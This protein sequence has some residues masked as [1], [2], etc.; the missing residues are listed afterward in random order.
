MQACWCIFDLGYFKLKAFA[1]LAT[2]GAYFLSRLNH[3]T[4]LLTTAAGRWHP[5]DLAHWLTTVEGQLL[6]RSIFLGEKERVASRLIA[7]RVPEAIVNERRRNAK[8]KAQKKG[9]TPSKAHLT[10]LAWNVF[11][12]N[13]PPSIWTTDTIGK[14]YPVRWQIELI[15]K[16]WKS[17]LH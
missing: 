14:V 13:V 7:S 1:R 9:Y 3:Q 10:L 4:T 5:V 11:I 12:T 8:K 16:S 6:E 17:Y 15:F 2:A